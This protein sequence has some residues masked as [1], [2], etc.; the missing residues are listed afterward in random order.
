VEGEDQEK[1]R[2]DGQA[3]LLL[4]PG[5]LMDRRFVATIIAFNF[6]SAVSQSVEVSTTMA[7]GE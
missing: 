4:C 1:T 6:N 7:H 3:L 2:I 5:Y